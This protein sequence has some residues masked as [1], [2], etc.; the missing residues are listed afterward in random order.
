MSQQ[1]V[2]SDNNQDS[3][4][5][6][7]IDLGSNSFHMM[8]ARLTQGELKPIDVMS[9]KVQLAAGLDANKELTEAAQERGLDCLSRFAQRIVSLPRSAV[10]IVG[11]NALRE[12]KNAAIFMEKAEKI[13]GTPL[14]IIAGREEARLIYLGVAHTLADDLGKRLVIDIGGGSTEFIIG[15]RFE[16]QELESLHMGCV[17]YTKRFFPDGIISAERFQRAKTAAMQELLSIRN[18]YREQG[19]SSCV[20]SSGTIKA[21]RNAI[22]SAGLSDESITAHALYKLQQRL[23]EFNSVDEIDIES[24]KPERRMVL[25]AGIAILSGILESLGIDK[26]DYS[27]GALR[28]GLLYDTIGRLEHED[29]RERTI[30]ALVTRYHVNTERANKIEH[31]ALLGWAQVKDD[32]GLERP[33]FHDMLSWAS[34]TH[35]IG[36]TISHSQFHKHSAYLLQNSDL[37]GFTKRDQQL[38]ASLARGHR[39][40]FPKEEFKK[41][42]KY[43][44]EP[45]RRLCILL[46]ISVLLHRSESTARLPAIIFRAEDKQLRL[47]FPESWLQHNPLTTA[48]LQQE[49]EHLKVI[50]Y[51]LSIE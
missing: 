18:R 6:A 38:V 35:Q 42:P 11:T 49:A 10:R 27:T 17:S 34:R 26:L 46:R 8:L 51:H 44:Q 9:E 50:D 37:P 41:L 24:I 19:W 23:L 40:K 21:V 12:A 13:L 43:L 33:I 32:W 47:R 16:P 29:V 15:E 14:E 7:A 48:D 3:T 30:N 45:Y 31:T 39:R 22:M 2:G 25:P 1:D 4:L 20:G 5:L 36:L 28:E